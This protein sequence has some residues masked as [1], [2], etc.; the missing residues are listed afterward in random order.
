MHVPCLFGL[1]RPLVLVK[2]LLLLADK[3]YTI[4][5]PNKILPLRTCNR[6]QGVGAGF[7]Y[8]QEQFGILRTDKVIDVAVKSL[9]QFTWVSRYFHTVL[10]QNA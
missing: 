9:Y 5:M 6:G 10:W 1:R 7:E 2:E 3:D 4:P 8:R